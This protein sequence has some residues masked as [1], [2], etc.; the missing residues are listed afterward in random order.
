VTLF[1]ILCTSI[2]DKLA[3]AFAGS[4]FNVQIEEVRA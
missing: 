1:E 2:S 3:A 4:T